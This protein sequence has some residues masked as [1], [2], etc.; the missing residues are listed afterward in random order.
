MQEAGIPVTYA[1]ISDVHD[2]HAGRGAYGPGEQGDVDALKA[3]DNA[4]AKFFDRLNADGINASNTLFIVTADENDHFAGQQAQNCD[5]VTIPCT[6]N[7]PGGFSL[8]GQYDVTNNGQSVTTWTGP[9][10]WP[11]VG[12]NGPLVWRDGLQHVLAARKHD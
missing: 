9:S 1:Y 3:Y 6:Y 8:H 5:G 7:T 4:F 10:T 12:T 2:N 11:P